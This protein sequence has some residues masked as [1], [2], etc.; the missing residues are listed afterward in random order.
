MVSIYLWN[1]VDTAPFADDGKGQIQYVKN[2][3]KLNMNMSD[4]RS[5]KVNTVGNELL[6]TDD[7]AAIKVLKRG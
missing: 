3:G 4:S 2:T 6:S 7:F 1:R 5:I